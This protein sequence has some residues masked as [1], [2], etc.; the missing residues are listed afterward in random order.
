MTRIEVFE[1]AARKLRASFAELQ[2]IPHRGEKG[3]QAEAI[4]RRFLNDHLPR[5][6]AATGGFILDQGDHLSKQTDVI[7]YD[8][9]NCPVYRADEDEEA[10]IIPNDNVAAVVEVKSRLDSDRLTEANENIAA[11][12]ALAKLRGSESG[13]E[14]WATLGCLFAFESAL[15][16]D[17]ICAKY[18]ELVSQ[19][20]IGSQIDVILVLDRGLIT[21]VGC[22][23][24]ASKWSKI[25]ALA[26]TGGAAGEGF[27]V[28]LA[29]TELGD[30]SLDAFLRIFVAHLTLFRHAVGHPGFDWSAL[31]AP[32]ETRIHY[33]T[34]F[35]QEREAPARAAKLR[36]YGEDFRKRFGGVPTS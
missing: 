23:P 36:E 4:V 21:W 22:A 35:T 25:G 20:K 12:K 18:K 3:G 6:F 17:T 8:A 33:V 16:L 1:R 15:T 31:G 30:R 10:C 13:P 28:G 32:A 19:A 11:A 24:G 2:N 26:D 7:V 34:S 29:G 9:F 5:R 14:Q 27:H